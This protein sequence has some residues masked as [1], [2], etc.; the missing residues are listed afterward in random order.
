[1]RKSATNYDVLSTRD[2]AEQL[3]VAL[4]TVQLWVEHGVLPAWKTAGGHRRISRAAVEKLLSERNAALQ[5]AVPS[6]ADPQPA[7]P[8]PLLKVLIVEDDVDERHLLTVVMRSW[9]LPIEIASAGN[10]FEALLKIGEIN[11][12]LLLT[13]LD[14]PGMDGFQMIGALQLVGSAYAHMKIVVVTGM[15][16][17]A[18]ERRGPL[19]PHVQVLAKPVP[20]GGLQGIVRDLLLHRGSVSPG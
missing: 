9:A 8:S 14:M 12:D 1:M 20:F 4:R 16:P 6:N 3:G 5:G 17:E 18:I 11:P 13:D 19:P 15:T 10:G 7:S 2:A